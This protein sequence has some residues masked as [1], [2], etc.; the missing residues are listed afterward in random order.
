[1]PMNWITRNI[2]TSLRTYTVASGDIHTYIGMLV[3]CGL[4]VPFQ[5]PSAPHRNITV[6]FAKSASKPYAGKHLYVTCR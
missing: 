1:M 4:V 3:Q 6:F 5:K 2:E